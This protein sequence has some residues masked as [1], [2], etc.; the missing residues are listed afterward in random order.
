MPLTRSRSS[1]NSTKQEGRAGRLLLAIQAL[2]DGDIISTASAARVYKVPRSTLR[3]R[4]G[5]I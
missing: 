2:K 5:G 3:H 1:E 4:L